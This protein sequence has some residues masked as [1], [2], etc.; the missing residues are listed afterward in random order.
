[1]KKRFVSE[2]PYL[3]DDTT[4]G[5]GSWKVIYQDKVTGYQKEIRYH[6]PEDG[7]SMEPYKMHGWGIISITKI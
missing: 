5:K 1:M 3:P 6:T 2:I 7:V 4:L